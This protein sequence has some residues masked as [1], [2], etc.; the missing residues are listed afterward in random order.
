MWNAYTVWLMSGVCPRLG[1]KPANLGCWSRAHGILTIQPRGQP[2]TLSFTMKMEV[3]FSTKR[4]V[5]SCLCK[6][7]SLGMTINPSDFKIIQFNLPQLPPFKKFSGGWSH[8][9]VVKSGVLCFG[10]PSLQV[11]IPGTDLHH[12]SSHAVVAT[13]IQNRGRL[14]QMLAQ[15]QYM[16]IFFFYIFIYMYLFIFWWGR[17]TLS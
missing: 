6:A 2:P 8:G 11:W 3:V 10:S 12:S 16:D 14:A 4:R 17:L 7:G 15:G 9:A 5:H 1:S 13:H